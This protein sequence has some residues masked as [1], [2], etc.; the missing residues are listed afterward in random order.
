M[1]YFAALTAFVEAAE[2]NN[3][4]RAAERLGIKASTV[5]RYV[6]DLEQD[7]GIALFNRSTRTLHLTEGGQTFLLHARRVL[8]E[9]EQAKAATSALNQQPRGVLKLN[10]PPAFARHHI[11]PVLNVFLVRYPQIK[12]EL[13]LD[14]AQV[15]LIHSGVDLAIRIGAL[16]DSTLKARKICAGKYLLVASP[17]FCEQYAAPAT[18]ADLA[19][20]PAILSAHDVAFEAG[21]EVLPLVYGDCIRINDLDAQLLAA[22]QGLGFALLPDWLVSKSVEAGEL[23]VW[24][25][26]WSILGAEQAF[27]VWFVY[28]PKRIV[29]SKVRCFIDFVVEQLGETP[30]WK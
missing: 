21:V 20:L 26:H 23:Q 30:Y 12:L 18:P 28:P 6:K 25:P 8:D 10:L 27:A 13:V 4:S 2:G 19:G 29:S 7:L 3:F 22:R 5:S 15:N 9:L 17:G 11:L 14:N 24:L 1:D 16:P